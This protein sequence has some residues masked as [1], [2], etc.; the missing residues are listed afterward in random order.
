M[1]AAMKHKLVFNL[2]CSFKTEKSRKT[3]TKTSITLSE[4][5]LGKQA[6]GDF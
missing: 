3:F 2:E 4:D 1:D 6:N 5:N